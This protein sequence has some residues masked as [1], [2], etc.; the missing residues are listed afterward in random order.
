MILIKA[1]IYK[2]IYLERKIQ[3][4]QS[5]IYSESKTQK[6]YEI[7]IYEDISPHWR[8]VPNRYEPQLV[9]FN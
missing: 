4:C 9:I 5:Q 1:Q 7:H 8:G 3:T 2:S 6:I